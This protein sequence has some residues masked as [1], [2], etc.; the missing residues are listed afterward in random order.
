MP[1]CPICNA[2]IPNFGPVRQH[3]LNCTVC[4][5]VYIPTQERIIPIENF[6]D[7]DGI[8][9]LLNVE[10]LSP[11][12]QKLYTK[13][14]QCAQSGIENFKKQGIMVDNLNAFEP[15]EK[16]MKQ[17]VDQGDLE[18]AMFCA[19][20]GMKDYSWSPLFLGTLVIFFTKICYQEAAL[21]SCSMLKKLAQ[22]P[23][24]VNQLCQM[25]NEIAPALLH[26]YPR[27]SRDQINAI[28]LSFTAMYSLNNQRMERGKKI[29]DRA[30]SIDSE[31]YEVYRQLGSYY[32]I[33]NDHVKAI[34]SVERSIQINPNN[35]RTHEFLRQILNDQSSTKRKGLFFH[36]K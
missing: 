5:Q 34:E 20:Q 7:P 32:W 19:L 30:M 3:I 22:P 14:L 21:R 36:K 18:E 26:L 9:D 4:R 15:W 23:Y 29:I 16:L 33:K 27:Y 28:V 1:R 17:K 13:D 8:L 2:P 35:P 6:L 12:F 25:A 24:P 11:A 10:G 31:N